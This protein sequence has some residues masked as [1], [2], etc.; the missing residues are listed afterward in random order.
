MLSRRRLLAAA[1]LLALAAC[2]APTGTAL[3]RARQAGELRLGIAG[4]RP[5][6][7]VDGSGRITGAQ[8]EVAREV[9]A[10]IGVDALLAVQVPFARLLPELLAG[11]FDLVA[12]G[13]SITPERC[14]QVAFTRPDFLSPPAFLVPEGNPRG[15]RTF[16]GVAR[17]GASVAVLEGSAEQGWARAAG[18]AE[19]RLLPSGGTG[20]LVRDVSD[21]R[22]DL[23]VL[24]ALTL[25]DQLARNP[26]TGLEVTGP[27][28]PVVDG[29]EVVAAAAFALRPGD[30]DLRAAFDAGLA[31]LQVSGGWER[32]V[33]PFGLTASVRPPPELTAAE[34]CAT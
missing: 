4:E 14:A 2:A 28:T 9:L 24:T 7:Y 16:G 10:G 11:S 12:A 30:A 21:G 13:L 23:G 25:S 34:L 33:A 8:P 22:A 6:G 5:Y 18:V 17:S 3:E 29:R 15:F 1:P 20:D 31:A 26:G 32:V 19:D 27:V